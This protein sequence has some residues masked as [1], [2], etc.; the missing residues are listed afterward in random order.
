VQRP[1]KSLTI[2]LTQR[3]VRLLQEQE[4]FSLGGFAQPMDV[5]CHF[6]EFKR[7]QILQ[8][9]DDGFDNAHCAW[10]VASLSDPNQ[11]ARRIDKRLLYAP[12]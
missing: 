1:F 12:D 7:G 10:K 6:H 8:I 4:P 9:F 2:L 3:A 5:P 11:A